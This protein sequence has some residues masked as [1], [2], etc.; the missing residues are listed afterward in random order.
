M[1]TDK[2]FFRI[3]KANPELFREF[4]G[5]KT[6]GP[7]T[8]KSETLKSLERR[9]DG[10]LEFV[11]R[12]PIVFIEIQGYRDDAV[13]PRLIA[14]M[15]QFNIEHPL[16]LVQGI[17]L[18]LKPEYDPCTYP[19]KSFANSGQPFFR[20]LYLEKVLASLAE[21]D[22]DHVLLS[23]FAP[24]TCRDNDELRR[25]AGIHYQK[26]RQ[27]EPQGKE[28]LL[29][30]FESGLMSRFKNRAEV[31]QIIGDIPPFEKSSAASFMRKWSQ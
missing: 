2:E 11:D 15:A 18:F 29:D 12:D 6:K 8:L 25:M 31:R 13:Y 30:A 4:L 7:C 1:Q 14:A 20:V 23:V 3:F 19:W 24:L 27:Y 9:V 10:V 22:P 16:R 5:I 17:I 26:L 21:K 28:G